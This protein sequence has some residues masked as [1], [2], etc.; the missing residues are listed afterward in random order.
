MGIAQ[1]LFMA[2]QS[3]LLLGFYPGCFPPI[4]PALVQ[5]HCFLEWEQAELVFAHTIV[6]KQTVLQKG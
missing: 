5:P 6:H 3:S 2:N 4:L 1:P